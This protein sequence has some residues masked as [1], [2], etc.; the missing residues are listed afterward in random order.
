MM[1]I[2]NQ[3]YWDQINAGYMA[4][5]S[6]KKT[7]NEIVEFKNEL[8]PPGKTIMKWSSSLNYQAHKEVPR[9]PILLS[10]KTYKLVID[11]DVRPV[12]TAIFCLRQMK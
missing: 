9:L 5:T 4:G 10:N 2:I 6:L 3:I 12:D 8:M 11:L 7:A 1:Q